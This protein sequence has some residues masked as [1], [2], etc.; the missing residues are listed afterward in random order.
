ML[1]RRNDDR[2]P[3]PRCAHVCCECFDNTHASLLRLIELIACLLTTQVLACL[4][5]YTGFRVFVSC[6]PPVDEQRTLV[7]GRLSADDAFAMRS[8]TVFSMLKR[9]G[10]HLNL[11]Q[12]QTEVKIAPARTDSIVFPS[13]ASQAQYDSNDSGDDDIERRDAGLVESMS[14]TSGQ[15]ESQLINV[16]LPVSVQVHLADDTRFYVTELARLFPADTPALRS[17]DTL[18]RVLRPE[19]ILRN[20]TPL[21]PDAYCD[22]ELGGWCLCISI[23]VLVVDVH[24]TMCVTAMRSHV[25]ICF[26]ANYMR[27]NVCSPCGL[28][29]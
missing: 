6:V 25:Y 15:L 21:S 16:C 5:D 7:Y 23:H 10:R 22:S 19:L 8:S 3:S 13:S 2:P 12:H 11:K 20:A 24:F 9:V 28:A 4:V 14:M 29:Q 1:Q 26:D 18:V 27:A 17:A